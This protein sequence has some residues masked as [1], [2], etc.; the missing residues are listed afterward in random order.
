MIRMMLI[1]L[2]S[3][4]IGACGTD[5]DDRPSTA[6]AD[7]ERTKTTTVESDTDEEPAMSEFLA[8]S[9][10][11][12]ET[13]APGTFRLEVAGEVHEGELGSC[14][15]SMRTAEGQNQD[16][17][18]ATANWR[19]DDGRNMQLEMWR[20]VMHDDFFWN[21]S[22]GHESDRVQLRLRDDGGSLVNVQDTAVS[23]MSGIRTRP[24]ASPRWRWGSGDMPAVRVS[25]D[26][27][28]ATA[29]GELHGEDNERGSPLTGPFSLAL[30]CAAE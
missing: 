9:L 16:R 10:H 8:E 26:G 3:L 24:G 20:F 13:A 2:I 11:S 5:N 7:T 19:T 1:L 30:S 18:S 4:A 28:Q 29:V 25:A 27:L 17:F 21:A 15:W 14:G 12:I 23:Q 22:H 6:N